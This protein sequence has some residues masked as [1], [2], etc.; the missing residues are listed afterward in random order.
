MLLAHV[1]NREDIIGTAYLDVPITLR[2]LD[3]PRQ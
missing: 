1:S 3:Q 2:R